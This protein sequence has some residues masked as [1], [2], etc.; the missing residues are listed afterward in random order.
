[1]RGI[2]IL[3][4]DEPYSFKLFEMVGPDWCIGHFAKTA[5]PLRGATLFGMDAMFARCSAA[6]VRFYNE[7][8]DL[9]LPGLRTAKQSHRPSWFL[10]KHSIA[11]LGSTFAVTT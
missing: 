7:E 5:W 4:D 6:G 9:G 8:Q 2:G 10:R 3:V 11:L 1:M